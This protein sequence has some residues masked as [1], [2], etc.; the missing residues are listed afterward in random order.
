MLE[1]IKPRKFFI[2]QIE[3]SPKCSFLAFNEETPHSASGI[4]ITQDL[5]RAWAFREI[6][7][8]RTQLNDYNSRGLIGKA[9]IVMGEIEY[10]PLNDNDRPMFSAAGPRQSIGVLA[11]LFGRDAR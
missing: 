10:T 9:Q 5:R 6:H 2:I 4:L 11:R 8:A 3:A 7:D 1:R